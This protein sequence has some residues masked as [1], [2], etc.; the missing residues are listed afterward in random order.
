MN[1]DFDLALMQVEALFVHDADGNLVRINEPEPT[2]PAPRF[3]M[4]RTANGNLWRTRHDLPVE[5]SLNLHRVAETIPIGLDQHEPPHYLPSLYALLMRHAPIQRVDSGPAYHLPES[6]PSS[7]AITVTAENLALL[8][9]HFAW[10]RDLDD[11]TPVV[12]MVED[13]IAVAA[14]FSSRL[15][16]RVA[17]AGVY[18]EAPYRG[19]G[20]ATEVVRDW[21]AGVRAAGRLPLY[22]T[23]WENKASQAVAR[24]LGAVQYGENFSIT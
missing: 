21:A 1:D 24:K 2:D 22:S 9:R 17:E 7:K 13:G 10:A 18:V 14:G 3:F 23:S 12:V 15:T 16:P 5:L 6:A 20:Y 19:R 8:D 4:T 11:Y